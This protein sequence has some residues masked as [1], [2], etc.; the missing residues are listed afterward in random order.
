MSKAFDMVNHS[1]LLSKLEFYG[2]RGLPL[3][4]FSSYLTN[5]KQYVSYN[6]YDS[7]HLDI[8]CGVPQ[9]SIV[10]PLLFLIFINDLHNVSEKLFFILFAD[11]SNLLLSGTDVN[12][13]CKQMN[14]ELTNVVNWFKLNKLCL[15]VKKTNFMIFSAKNKPYSG[16]ELSISVDNVPVDLVYQTK[17]LGVFIDS[18]LS[19][20]SPINHVASKI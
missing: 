7:L 8:L 1:I 6:G 11:D 12:D 4:W 17:F 19:W 14:H 3:Q 20:T 13:L 10:G 9:G 16:S 15:N 18:K 5:R 2:V